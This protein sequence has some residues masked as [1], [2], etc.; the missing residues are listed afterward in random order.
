MTTKVAT[1]IE[2]LTSRLRGRDLFEIAGLVLKNGSHA[3]HGLSAAERARRHADG[4]FD[5]RWGTDTSRGMSVHDLGI[6][7]PRIA[8]CRRYDPSSEAMLHAPIA[9]LGIDPA[10]FDF[11]DYGAGK[12]RALMLASLMGFRSVTGIELSTKLCDIAR[13]NLDRFAA[14]NPALPRGLVIGADATQ[15]LPEGRHI[16]AYL[17]N[18]FDAT[19]LSTVRERLED[20]VHSGAE[21][22]RIVYANPD[23]VGVFEGDDRWTVTHLAPGLATVTANIA[24]IRGLKLAA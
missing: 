21:T 19:I 8:H 12:G 14:Q 23:H 5:R 22:L 4:G 18:P 15:V 7:G 2:R 10:R 20:A 6:S 1:M 24:R 13:A 3:L 11:I 16:L 17:Y 9:A